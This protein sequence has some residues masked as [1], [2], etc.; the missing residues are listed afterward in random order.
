MQELRWLDHL[1]EGSLDGGIRLLNRLRWFIRFGQSQDGNWVVAAGH[2]VIFKS[3]SREAVDAFLYGMSLS[4]AV[5]KQELQD[6]FRGYMLEMSGLDP[7]D[8]D[9]DEDELRTR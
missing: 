2:C 4:Y 7:S 5:M 8:P 9:L 1:P 3:D 6:Q